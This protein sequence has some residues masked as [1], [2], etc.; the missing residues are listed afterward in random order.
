MDATFHESHQTG[1]IFVPFRH[2]FSRRGVQKRDV[3]PI[4]HVMFPG[5]RFGLGDFVVV[6][7]GN[8][9]DGSGVDVESFPDSA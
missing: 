5:G 4:I 3:H 2:F 1:E 6:M 9:I 7:N 8:Q